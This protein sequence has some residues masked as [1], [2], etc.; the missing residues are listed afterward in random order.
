MK[1]PGQQDF[2][3]EILGMVEKVVFSLLSPCVKDPGQQ[4]FLSEIL[5]F[6]GRKHGKEIGV[7][8][9]S[10]HCIPKN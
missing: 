7:P 8:V 4:D 10:V 3:S 6:S 2:L 1:D 9:Q 5:R